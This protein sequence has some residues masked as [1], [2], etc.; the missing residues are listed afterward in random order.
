MVNIIHR[1]ASA[2]FLLCILSFFSSTVISMLFSEAPGR[3]AVKELIVFPG[4]ILLVLAAALTGITGRL[5]AFDRSGKLIEKKLKRMKLI[6]ANGVIILIPCAFS[7]RYMA[8]NGFFDT[9][10]YAVQTL[11]LAA[12]FLNIVLIVMNFRAGFRL[13]ANKRL[14]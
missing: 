13:S 5:L 11:E 10:Y 4:L 8:V 3:T 14:I 6:A 1:S 7:L 9:I 12:G 2:A